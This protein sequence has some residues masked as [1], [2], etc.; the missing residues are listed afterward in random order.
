[1]LAQALL[2]LLV[3]GIDHKLLLKPLMHLMH[4]F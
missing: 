3:L 4:L 1:V 2:Q